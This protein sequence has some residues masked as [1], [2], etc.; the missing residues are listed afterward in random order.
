VRGNLIA[1]SAEAWR[2]LG[3]SAPIGPLSLEAFF[4]A[5]HADDREQ[6]SG[7]CSRAVAGGDSFEIEHRIMLPEGSVKHL[8]QQVE[9]VERDTGGGA[10]RMAGAVHDVTRRKEAEEQIRRLAY[11]DALT[12]LPNRRLI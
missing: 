5:V 4:A 7:A 6:L 1:P 2:I 12:G 8:H 11:Y 9:V 10:V 3:H